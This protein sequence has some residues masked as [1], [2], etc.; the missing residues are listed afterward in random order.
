M[1]KK[2]ESD[3]P[4]DIDVAT[5]TSIDTID[6]ARTLVALHFNKATGMKTSYFGSLLRLWTRADEE[7]QEALG[8]AYPL[9]AKAMREYYNAAFRGKWVKDKLPAHYMM[10]DRL[11]GLSF[12]FTGH[13]GTPTRGDLES[14]VLQC[15]GL[16]HYSLTRNTN[17]LVVGFDT[18]IRRKKKLALQY[19]VPMIDAE[20]F[21]KM[22]GID[23]LTGER[24]DV[25]DE[26][27]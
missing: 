27:S 26:I 16:L 23:A 15:G 17:Y 14:Y 8:L 18:E 25:V 7:N 21:L 24:T 1:T 19:R 10:T 6:E 9:I 2:K 12:V 22:I 3:K 13:F 11:A 5:Y 4:I 20:Q